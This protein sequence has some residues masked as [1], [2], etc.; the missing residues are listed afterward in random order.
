M[1]NKELKTLKDLNEECK[2][3]EECCKH[4]LKQEAIKRIR[5]IK[6]IFLDDTDFDKS[7]ARTQREAYFHQKG[8]ADELMSFLNITEEDLK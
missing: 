8:K 6:E 7:P 4:C 2:Y 3:M 1:E 5:F